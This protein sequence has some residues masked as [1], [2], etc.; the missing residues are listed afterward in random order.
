MK[1]HVAAVHTWQPL[2]SAVRIILRSKASTLGTNWI[3]VNSWWV[4]CTVHFLYINKPNKCMPNQ[5][6]KSNSLKNV[7]T[8]SP[9]PSLSLL[10]FPNVELF[11]RFLINSSL[12]SILSLY[13][14]LNI[15]SFF[16]LLMISL[17][18]FPDI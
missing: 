8:Y 11:F 2:P 3:Y 15:E 18:P 13:P 5:S 9:C 4:E 7:Y 10:P 6:G 1:K 12:W 16:K 14:F 17:F